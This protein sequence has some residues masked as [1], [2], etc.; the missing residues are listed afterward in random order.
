MSY[1][2]Y[3]KP[4]NSDITAEDVLS[5]LS[6]RNVYR[7]NAGQ[8]FYENEDTG[9]YFSFERN[10]PLEEEFG[11]EEESDEEEG[12]SIDEYPIAFNI[13]LFRPSYFALEAE[14]ELSRVVGEFDLSI[15]D[16]QTSGMGIGE[17]D[18]NRFIQG[19]NASNRA[20]ARSILSEPE[21]RQEIFSMPCAKLERIW[22][23][24]YGKYEFQNELGDS[25]F[26]PQV[27]FFE[28][29][30]GPAA[31]LVW[32]DAIPTAFTEVDYVA[33]YRDEYAPRRWFRR[34]EYSLD[35]VPW[36]DVEQLI[37]SISRKEGD[38]FLA[39]YDDPPT[40]VREY[41]RNLKA[42]NIDAA[43]I[44]PALVLDEELFDQ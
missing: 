39:S 28:I 40:E 41:F 17:Y 29:N 3:L 31:V 6:E 42:K 1:D 13:N 23:W 18:A 15:F 8:A 20:A 38:V 43:A 11:D 36:G 34:Q 19:W 25:I 7:V 30:D 10:E 2:T 27:M 33:I 9:V 4:R 24:N 14:M 5:F 22:R 26:V 16:P 44:D 32:S 12:S 35:F 37:G 21:D